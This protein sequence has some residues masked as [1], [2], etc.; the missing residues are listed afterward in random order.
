[1]KIVRGQARTLFAGRACR[2]KSGE[3]RLSAFAVR[4]GDQYFFSPVG[5]AGVVGCGSAVRSD[6]DCDGPT[7]GGADEAA[8]PPALAFA[9]C[10]AA[11]SSRESL[12]S[13]FL[14]SLSKSFSCGEPFA[15]SREMKPSLFLSRSLNIC[16]ASELAD[17]LAVPPVAEAAAPLPE[18]VLEALSPPA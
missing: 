7:A 10:A 16:S 4:P 5:A 13:P 2:K 9:L 11:C 8:V 17:A 15:S 3:H 12:P 14:S 18:L 6:D 1:A